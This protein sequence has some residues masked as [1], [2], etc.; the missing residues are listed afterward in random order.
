MQKCSLNISTQR[1]RVNKLTILLENNEGVWINSVEENACPHGWL[2]G[3]IIA[4]HFSDL[5]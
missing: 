1:K 4:D 5:S 2:G 3:R